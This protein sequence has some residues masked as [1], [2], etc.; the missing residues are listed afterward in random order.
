MPSSRTSSAPMAVRSRSKA[1]GRTRPQSMTYAVK[2]DGSVQ[3]SSDRD[4]AL[5][6]RGAHS[7]RRFEGSPAKPGD[8]WRGNFYRFNRDRDGEPEQLSWSPTMWPGFHQP[9]RFGYLRFS[10]GCRRSHH[11]RRSRNV[12]RSMQLLSSAPTSCLKRRLHGHGRQSRREGR[13]HRRRRRTS[14]CG[15]FEHSA[16]RGPARGCCTCHGVIPTEATTRGRPSNWRLAGSRSTRSTCTAG[17]IRGRAVLSRG[18]RGLRRRCSAL[19]RLAKSRQPSLPSSCSAT[20][21]AASLLRLHARAPGGARRAHLRELCLPGSSARYRAGGRQGAQP[22]RA[23]RARAESART[24][25]SR[26]IRGGD[27]RC[28]TIR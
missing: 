2:V 22:P 25:T 7:L 13:T 12:S 9:A 11:E 28:S 18:D 20:A 6:R 5:D 1:T 19:V 27:R 24:R 26:A 14:D 3:N 8:V 17:A 21:P 10:G 4:T 15:A 16:S 23:A